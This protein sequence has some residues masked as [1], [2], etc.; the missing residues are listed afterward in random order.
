[1]TERIADRDWW[2][3]GIKIYRESRCANCGYG[4]GMKDPLDRENRCMNCNVPGSLGMFPRV[5]VRK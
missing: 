2:E 5:V 3:V 4:D 1:M